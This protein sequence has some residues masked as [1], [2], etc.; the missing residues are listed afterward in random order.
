MVLPAARLKAAPWIARFWLLVLSKLL[1][2]CTCWP[3]NAPAL[4]ALK[5]TARLPVLPPCAALQ[6]DAVTPA[7]LKRP[8]VMLPPFTLVWIAPIKPGPPGFE[9]PIW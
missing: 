4:V 2:M 7:P 9:L 3:V 6:F 1:R 5:V 8:S